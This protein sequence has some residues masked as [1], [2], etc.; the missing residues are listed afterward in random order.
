MNRNLRLVMVALLCLPSSAFP[1]INVLTWHNDLART[2]Q[3]LKEIQLTPVNVNFNSFGKLFQINVDG[4]VDAQPL[5]VSNVSIPNRGTHNVVIITTE[6]DSV[7]CCDAD[8][9]TVLWRKSMLRSGETPSD[10][11][12]CDQVVPEIELRLRR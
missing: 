8:F 6:H 9:G 7:Y 3:N 10:S 5:I 1:A 4:K 11:R 2:G 12:G